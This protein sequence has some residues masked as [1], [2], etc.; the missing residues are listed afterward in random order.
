MVMQRSRHKRAAECQP[1]QHFRWASIVRFNKSPAS[2]HGCWPLPTY[3][4]SISPNDGQP[5]D[6]I[7]CQHTEYACRSARYAVHNTCP[8]LQ[9]PL[10]AG[11]IE[12]CNRIRSQ[13][14]PN[15]QTTPPG[16]IQNFFVTPQPAVSLQQRRHATQ[17]TAI[18]EG[19]V[20][21]IRKTDPLTTDLSAGGKQKQAGIATLRSLVEAKE[22]SKQLLTEGSARNSGQT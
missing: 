20:I 6:R 1:V 17:T 18:V 9:P 22:I 13:K 7:A 12:R 8:S 14:Q 10:R 19:R 3:C 2:L 21:A 5:C 16:F 15:G 4:I 11:N